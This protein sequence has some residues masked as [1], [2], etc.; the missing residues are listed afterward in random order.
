[1]DKLLQQL[2]DAKFIQRYQ[3]NGRRLI[4]IPG[5]LE[6][7]RPH[8]KEV[9]STLP[10]PEGY[11]PKTRPKIGA[12]HQP[13]HLPKIGAQHAQ[14]QE[15]GTEIQEQEQGTEEPAAGRFSLMLEMHR[16]VFS[17]EPFSDRLE[18]MRSDAAI[19]SEDEIRAAYDEARNE[20]ARHQGFVHDALRR[21]RIG[22]GDEE[23]ENVRWV[24]EF[25]EYRE[26]VAR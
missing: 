9:P 7:Q 1:M 2:H 21:G 14:E 8:S 13:Q 3:A 25:H 10:P 18:E 4:F 11:A 12:Q 20:G 5:F 24:R 19:Y 22:E 6:H 26:R 15:Q 23:D 16:D 17:R